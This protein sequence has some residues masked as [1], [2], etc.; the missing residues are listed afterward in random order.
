MTNPRTDLRCVGLLIVAG[1]ALSGCASMSENECKVADWQR[2]GERDGEQGR[3]DSR[4]ADHAEA[5]GKIGIQPDAARYRRGWDYGVLR[6]CTAEVG[7]RE[8][9]NGSTYQGVCRGRNEG[10]FLRFHRA[11]LEVHRV[12]Q[13]IESNHA[14]SRRLED[15]LK[16][17]RTDDER[18]RLRDRLRSLDREQSQLRQRA[19]QLRSFGP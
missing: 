11:G 5:C 14:E 4:L 2:I 18:K 8:G 15:Q 10:E 12:E 1:L 19:A 6:Y 17:A 7:W 16:K 9:L 3:P 13:D